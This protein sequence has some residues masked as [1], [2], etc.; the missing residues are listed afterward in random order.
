MQVNTKIMWKN[1]L[2]MEQQIR[3]KEEEL[4]KLR[5]FCDRFAK[6]EYKEYNEL[7]GIKQRME[8]ELSYERKLW[9]A[10]EQIIRNYEMAERHLL[11]VQETGLEKDRDNRL[12][13][14]GL[15][16]VS[17]WLLQWKVKV[18]KL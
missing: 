2:R 6:V 11:Q 9:Q 18:R 1:F 13:W 5:G 14:I 16:E 4:E 10:L 3:R 8:R 12:E 15:E 7:F 17:D